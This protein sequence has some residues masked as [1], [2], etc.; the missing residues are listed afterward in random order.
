MYISERLCAVFLNACIA[1]SYLIRCTCISAINP[2]YISAWNLQE[3]GSMGL[4]QV[5]QAAYMHGGGVLLFYF[6]LFYFI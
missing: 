3:R 1:T 4:Q 6:I 2:I 5:Q